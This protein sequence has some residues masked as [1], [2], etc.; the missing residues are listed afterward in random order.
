[1]YFGFVYNYKVWKKKC[2]R[3]RGARWSPSTNMATMNRVANARAAEALTKEA[4]NVQ[5]RIFKMWIVLAF[6]PLCNE[7]HADAY[8]ESVV[9]SIMQRQSRRR[10]SSQA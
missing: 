3:V 8:D 7:G 5:P 1:M 4:L 2:L 10:G 9:A 6:H